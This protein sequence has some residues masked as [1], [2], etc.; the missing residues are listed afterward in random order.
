MLSSTGPQAAPQARPSAAPSTPPSLEAG[1]TVPNPY[2]ML[3]GS[4]GSAR[5]P[6]GSV[7]IAAALTDFLSFMYLIFAV[8]RRSLTGGGLGLPGTL[9]STR[10]VQSAPRG[11][12]FMT[13]D[14][15]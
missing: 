12:V 3:S 1:P 5:V 7:K 6:L 10:T 2:Q 8:S 9:K 4:L 15:V 14:S 11:P 13:H